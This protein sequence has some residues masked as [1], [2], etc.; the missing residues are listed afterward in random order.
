MKNIMSSYKTYREMGGSM[1]IDRLLYCKMANEFNKDI[2]ELVKDGHQ[3]KLP[4]KMGIL[5]VKGKKIQSEYDEELGRISNQAPD[6][7]ETN[8]LWARC[9]E[10]KKRKQMVYHEN[11]HSD[12]IRYKY[13]WSKDRMI[14]ENKLFYT[15]VLTRTNKRQLS[16]LIQ[17]GREYHVEPTKY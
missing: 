17:G 14:V 6:F 4:E 8:K 7:G 16:A 3:V 9:P 15:M 12:G 13:F 11:E 10:C 1:D 5:S 2:I